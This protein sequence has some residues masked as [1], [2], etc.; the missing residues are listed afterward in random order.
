MRGRQ[1]ATVAHAG[2]PQQ[3]LQMNRARWLALMVFGEDGDFQHGRDG[4]FGALTRKP[5]YLPKLSMLPH[6]HELQDCDL[7]SLSLSI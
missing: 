2:P 5:S 4:M 7:N 1:S 3:A 6:R